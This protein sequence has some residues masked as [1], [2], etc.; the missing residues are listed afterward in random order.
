[1][2]PL[3][4]NYSHCITWL[5]LAFCTALGCSAAPPKS[6]TPDR[7]KEASAKGEKA[8]RDD[9]RAS[10]IASVE[11]GTLGPY[12]GYGAQGALALYAP[13]AKDD[14]Q[15]KW[16]V[17]RIDNKGN[18]MGDPLNIGASPEDVPF[19]IVREANQGYLA[20]WVRQIHRADVLEGV[21]LDKQGSLIGDIATIS[22]ARGEV[23]WG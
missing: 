6:Q 3:T 14:E 15:R 18:A 23:V 11:G 2:S 12:I 20:L 10:I 5:T 21:L 13:P 22:Q 9:G 16:L 17:Q 7:S 4:M 8:Q 1:M 19:A